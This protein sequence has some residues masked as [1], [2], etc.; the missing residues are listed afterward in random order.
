MTSADC[1]ICRG[2]DGDAEW[3]RIQVWEDDLWRLTVSLAAEVPGF[4]YL[5]PKRHIPSIADLDGEEARTFGP[6]LARVTKALR[7]ETG[8]EQV[9]VY[10][11]GGGVPHIHLHLAPH[12]AGDA[13][14]DQMIRGELVETKME[15]GITMF[16]SAEFPPLPEAQL[17]EV[18]ARIERRL[19]NG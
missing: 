4:A 9:Y 1:I 16:H 12:R 17:R 14:S 8:A 6:V 11:F 15:S 10:V 7:A 2:R 13:L 5:E 19:R 3:H 18:A